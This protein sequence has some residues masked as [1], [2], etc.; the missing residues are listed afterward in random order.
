MIYEYSNYLLIHVVFSIKMS[1]TSNIS[2]K[3]INN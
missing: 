3:K 1:S 2:Y